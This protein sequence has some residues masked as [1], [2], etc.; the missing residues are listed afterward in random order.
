MIFVTDERRWIKWHRSVQIPHI[1][2][3]SAISQVLCSVS[4]NK[5]YKYKFSWGFIFCKFRELN[6]KR[7]NK[8]SQNIFPSFI[9]EWKVCTTNDT[10]V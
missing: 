3:D 5:L 10:Q 6:H 7:K 4:H 8:N 2:F 9:N 1:A